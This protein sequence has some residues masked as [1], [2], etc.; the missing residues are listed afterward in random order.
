[1][2]K[3]TLSGLGEVEIWFTFDLAQI[4]NW[5]QDWHIDGGLVLGAVRCKSPSKAV[6][7]WIDGKLGL[8]GPVWQVCLDDCPILVIHGKELCGPGHL[9]RWCSLTHDCS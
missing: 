8:L 7:T 3:T 2:V 1:M 9:N 4:N 6:K 5:S